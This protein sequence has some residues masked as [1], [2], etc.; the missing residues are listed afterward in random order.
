[1]S[2]KNKKNKNLNQNNNTQNNKKV[3]INTDKK[4]TNNNQDKNKDKNVDTV[5]KDGIPSNLWDKA[6]VKGYDNYKPKEKKSKK[7]KKKEERIDHWF[8]NGIPSYFWDKVF[9]NGY[10]EYKLSGGK[11]NKETYINQ[12][13]VPLMTTFSFIL[14]YFIPIVL[15]VY[16]K[17]TIL[18]LCSFIIGM[19]LLIL[20]MIINKKN[21]FTAKLFKFTVIFALVFVLLYFFGAPLLDKIK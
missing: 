8:K 10:E 21:S 12:T 2:K 11:D 19:S 3:N 1:M 20:S 14:I 7:Q 5:F 6:F 4:K 16:S 9:T 17:N 15:F 13:E 18:V